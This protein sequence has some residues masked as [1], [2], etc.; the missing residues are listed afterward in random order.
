MLGALD[1]LLGV[2]CDRV[3]GGGGVREGKESLG[4]SDVLLVE[5]VGEESPEDCQKK[6]RLISSAEAERDSDVHR[7]MERPA[8]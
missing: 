5:E 8:E 6:G 3:V 2:L 4:F 1:D 7:A